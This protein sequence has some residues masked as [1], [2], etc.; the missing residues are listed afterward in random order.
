[1]DLVDGDLSAFW[2][3]PAP[4]ELPALRATLVDHLRSPHELEMTAQ[5][6]AMGKGSLVPPGPPRVAAATLLRE[7]QARLTDAELYYV[8]EDMA[9]LARVAGEGLPDYR[10]EPPDV[11]SPCGF[12]VFASPIGGYVS[13]N[14]SEGPRRNHVVACSWGHSGLNRQRP[15]VWL[16]FWCA[17]NHNRLAARLVREEGYKRADAERV[18]RTVRAELAWDNEAYLVYGGDGASVRRPDGTPVA[19]DELGENSLAPWVQTVRAAWLLMTQPGITDVQ[20]ERLTRQQQRRAARE[21]YTTTEVRIVRLRAAAQAGEATH[22]G[23]GGRAYTV[24]WMVRGHWRQ[25]PYGPQRTLRRPVWINP[26][27]KGPADAPLARTERVMLV[28]RD[29][30]EHGG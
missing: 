3:P 22:E 14:D 2:T 4:R 16:T 8:T 25:Q 13:D 7:E 11:P 10:I 17:T 9:T 15:G 27:V 6:L 26:H 29:R 24:R 18:V 19:K 12:V 21:G 20:H 30:R 5:V 23:D 1:M 28:D